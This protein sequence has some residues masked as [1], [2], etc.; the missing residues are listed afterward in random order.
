MSLTPSA[1]DGRKYESSVSPIL[2]SKTKGAGSSSRGLFA[3]SSKEAMCPSSSEAE[4]EHEPESGSLLDT[5]ERS[6]SSSEK[7]GVGGMSRSIGES[8]RWCACA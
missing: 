2:R 3:I 7:G 8:L 5:E 6:C 4:G 1:R